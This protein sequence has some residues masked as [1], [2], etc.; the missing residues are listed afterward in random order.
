MTIERQNVHCILN[1]IESYLLKFKHEIK[2]SNTNLHLTHYRKIY[3]LF[4]FDDGMVD[5]ESIDVLRTL[6][7]KKGINE[8]FEV[9]CD[10]RFQ[11]NGVKREIGLKVASSC[12]NYVSKEYLLEAFF[13]DEKKTNSIELIT[14]ST[15]FTPVTITIPVSIPVPV[16]TKRL[17][18]CVK[19]Y[20]SQSRMGKNIVERSLIQ[21]LNDRLGSKRTIQDQD[22]LL[23]TVLSPET[24]RKLNVVDLVLKTPTSSI[25]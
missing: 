14:P 18:Q 9:E 11:M 23:C 24:K 19:P 21:F 12:L 20:G 16:V 25:T 4:L 2:A 6:C 3:K 7:Q 8:Y 17:V 13:P 15:K 5:M 10:I 1:R 22:M